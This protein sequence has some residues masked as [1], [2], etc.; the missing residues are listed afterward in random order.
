[1]RKFA[2]A[3]IAGS[4]MAALLQG[5]VTPTEW[6][7]NRPPPPPP[8][9]H[10]P[11]HKTSGKKSRNTESSSSKPVTRVSASPN[12]TPPVG[13]NPQILDQHGGG[14]GGG[15]GGGW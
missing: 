13:I 1:M 11:V 2:A 12:T 9:K 3:A 10:K 4:L 7:W 6:S 15:G 8:E 5:C 14:G